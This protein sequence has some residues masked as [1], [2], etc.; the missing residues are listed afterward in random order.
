MHEIQTAEML[1]DRCGGGEVG[2]ISQGRVTYV[3]ASG[4]YIDS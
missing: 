4:H 1:H 3:L 2:H